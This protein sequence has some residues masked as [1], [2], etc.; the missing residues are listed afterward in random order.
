MIRNFIKNLYDYR[1]YYVISIC[2]IAIII[3]IC[4]FFVKHPCVK[5]HYEMQWQTIWCYSGK[6]YHPCGGYFAN[7]FVC[8]CRK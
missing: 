6:N 7:V 4:L 2:L 5:G 8:D 1:W 3:K